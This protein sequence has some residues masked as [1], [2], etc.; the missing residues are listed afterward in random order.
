MQH[1]TRD[2]YQGP[3]DQPGAPR[4]PAGDLFALGLIMLQLLTGQEVAGLRAFVAGKLAPDCRN[5]GDI[6]DPCAPGWPSDNAARF[7]RLAMR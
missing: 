5:V 6:A 3:E 4:R 2:A 7:A 1:A